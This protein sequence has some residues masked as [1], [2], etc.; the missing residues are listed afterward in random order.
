MKI[1]VKTFTVAEIFQRLKRN[2]QTLAAD[3]L[4]VDLR[5]CNARRNGHRANALLKQT[6]EVLQRYNVSPQKQWIPAQN[7]ESNSPVRPLRKIRARNSI[8]RSRRLRLF[9]RF[10][11]KSGPL[12][13]SNSRA[14]HCLSPE[15]RQEEQCGNG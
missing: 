3:N 12:F 4:S 8:R 7:W 2:A 14:R 10:P 1:R 6:L 13:R 9:C 15:Q 11:A 5:A